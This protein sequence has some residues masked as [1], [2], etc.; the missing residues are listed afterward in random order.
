LR[1]LFIAACVDKPHC[2]DK[3]QENCA[4]HLAISTGWARG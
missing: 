4:A 3:R 2:L 1:V